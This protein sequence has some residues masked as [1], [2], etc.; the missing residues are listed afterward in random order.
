MKV[1]VLGSGESGFEKITKPADVTLLERFENPSPSFRLDI[2]IGGYNDAK[3]FTSL[4]PITGQPDFGR[5]IVKYVP[6]KW[7]L[8]SKSWKL[9][10]ASY[11][12]HA[13]FSEACIVQITHDLK[14][15]LKPVMLHVAGEFTPRGGISVN[16][17]CEYWG[18]Y[19]D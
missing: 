16:P 14:K 8:E 15:F 13:A 12:N 4:C 5:I 2:Q 11:R 18:K 3:E 17:S 10:L 7:C 19:D 9:Y 6:K 1:K